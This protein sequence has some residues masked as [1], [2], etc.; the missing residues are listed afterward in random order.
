MHGNQGRGTAV[1]LA[2]A[3][4]MSLAASA[5]V[6]GSAGWSVALGSLLLSV[7]VLLL[8]L[9]RQ[10]QVR[11]M[12]GGKT[13]PIVLAVIGLGSLS[14]YA[15]AHPVSAEQLAWVV[16]ILAL[17]AVGLGAVRAYTVRLWTDV[18]GQTWRQG[19]WWTIALWLVGIAAHIVAD[20]AAGVGSASAL[21]YLGL[22][23]TVQRLV[24]GTRAQRASR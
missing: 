6:G 19:T 5:R 14:S 20:G 13:L 24:L 15:R 9:W 12:R 7:A 1:L 3:L 22:T 8:I 18:S 11:R 10:R 17:D 2:A 16:A 23:L 4:A 21:L